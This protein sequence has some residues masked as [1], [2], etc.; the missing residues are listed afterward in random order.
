M[1]SLKRLPAEKCGTVVAGILIDSLVLG[2][3][4]TRA[5]RA[6]GLKLP[7]PTSVI[8]SGEEDNVATALAH[9]A[10]VNDWLSHQ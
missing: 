4:P 3:M 8:S 10:D 6:L 2:F 1:A 5:A 9:V 7:K